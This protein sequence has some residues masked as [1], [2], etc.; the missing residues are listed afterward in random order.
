MKAD[1]GSSP[2]GKADGQNH[3]NELGHDV[4]TVAEAAALLRLNKKTVYDAVDRNELPHQ[5]IGWKIR[6]SRTA[7][8]AW[9]TQGQG[10]VSRSKRR[11][12]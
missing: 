2:T 11:K 7:L 9:L 12:P 6:I 5:R 10:R 1:N 3:V 8:L 4:L